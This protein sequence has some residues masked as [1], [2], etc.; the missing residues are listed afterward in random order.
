MELNQE[1]QK[2]ESRSVHTAKWSTAGQ[3][4]NKKG[5]RQQVPLI[6]QVCEARLHRKKLSYMQR[7]N[8]QHT[9]T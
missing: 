3:A 6:L 4:R 7:E 9:C 5:L 2:D 1:C 8:G